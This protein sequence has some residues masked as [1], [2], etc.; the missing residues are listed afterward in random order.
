MGELSCAI[1]VNPTMS[2]KK[3]VELGYVSGDTVLPSF[4]SFATV[5]T[6]SAKNKAPV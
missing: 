4:S 3:T 5:L 1:F 2:L 6:R